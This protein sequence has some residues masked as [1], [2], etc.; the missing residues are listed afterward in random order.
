LQRS[1]P[2][3]RTHP[4]FVLSGR[5][6]RRRPVAWLNAAW[7]HNR[8]E[9]YTTSP[10]PFS[11]IV[12]KVSYAYRGRNAPFGAPPA[13]I[14]ACGTTAPGSYLGWLTHSRRLV[15]LPHAPCPAHSTLLPGSVSGSRATVQ[16]SPWSPA[17]PPAPPQTV[18]DPCSAHSWVLRQC[19]TSQQRTHRD[20]DHRSSPIAP[21]P[22]AIGD[23]WDL[24][25]LV[26]GASTRAQGLRLR[27][28][29]A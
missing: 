28:V 13:Q 6:I 19:Q 7:Q 8:L 10:E 24:P 22:T 17:F 18:T 14:P 1:R 5:R 9:T 23:C 16:S 3:L 27:R 15:L 4:P 12:T 11:V 2:R 26:H 25:V 21:G 29:G 20:Y